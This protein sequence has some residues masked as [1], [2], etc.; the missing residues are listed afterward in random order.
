MGMP[1]PDDD[2]PRWSAGVGRRRADGP[3]LLRPARHAHGG[4]DRRCQRHDGR[5][6]RVRSSAT[7]ASTPAATST[8]GSVGPPRAAPT[9]WS[10]TTITSPSRS[11][12]SRGEALVH[13]FVKPQEDD[14]LT[15]RT[16]GRRPRSSASAPARRTP[17]SWRRSPRI[18]PTARHCRS[19]TADAMANMT[20][21]DDGLPR[22]GSA[23]ASSPRASAT[24][25]VGTAT[26]R[27]RCTSV[28]TRGRRWNVR[29]AVA[30]SI[31]APRDAAR[32]PRRRL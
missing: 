12:G 18:S 6:P 7:P 14:R 30:P 28:H 3:G 22:G 19:T 32:R 29:S 11:S 31:R 15:I 24:V 9:A 26:R 16:P 1:A 10:T 17:T 25:R 4:Q 5:S 8:C 13:D 27:A 21:I 2:D 23:T 20:L